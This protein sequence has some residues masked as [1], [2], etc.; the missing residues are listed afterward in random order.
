MLPL[1]IPSR[2]LISSYDSGGSA[3]SRYSSSRFRGA[4]RGRAAALTSAREGTR[5]T[6]LHINVPESCKDFDSG[7]WR[8]LYFKPMEKYF[9]RTAPRRRGVKKT[10]AAA[11]KRR[12]R[13]RAFASRPPESTFPDDGITALCA[14][15]KRVIE[16][17]RITTSR[18]CSTRRLA[19]SITMSA[20]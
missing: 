11:K 18:L 6:L 19:F 5:I 15:A 8:D 12:G 1:G 16:S 2:A 20:T 13:W 10:A 3:S 9:A 4:R 14:R 7:G 17:S